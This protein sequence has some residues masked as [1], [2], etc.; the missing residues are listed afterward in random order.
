M[1]KPSLKE[2]C[3]MQI[4]N[5]LANR[6]TKFMFNGSSNAAEYKWPNPA[7]TTLDEMCS[8]T[9]QSDQP[10]WSGQSAASSLVRSAAWAVA[11]SIF[12]A[13]LFL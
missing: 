13:V 8:R 4:D 7:A 10:R 3:G 9:E 11:M 5:A 1:D 6:I 2:D 12:S